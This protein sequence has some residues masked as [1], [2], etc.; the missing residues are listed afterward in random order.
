MDVLRVVKPADYVPPPKHS[1]QLTVRLDLIAMGRQTKPDRIQHAAAD[2]R[3]E[4][5]ELRKTIR[6]L[7]SWIPV[8][9][10]LPEEGQ[11]CLV[12]SE[13]TDDEFCRFAARWTGEVWQTNGGVRW[14][15]K[16]LPY[17]MPLPEPP[18]CAMCSGERDE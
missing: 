2:A 11:E 17:W 1:R 14:N 3:T 12:Y 8:S 7:Q 6:Q 15:A 16:L 13:N 5:V 10:R 4:I 18:D 9:E